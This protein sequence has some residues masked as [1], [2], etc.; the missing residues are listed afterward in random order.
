[1]TDYTAERLNKK[2]ASA[3]HY[4]LA[5]L[6]PYTEANVKLAFKPSAFF[7]DLEKLD[8][9]KASKRVLENAYYRAIKSGLIIFDDN[10]MPRLT[11]KAIRKIKPYKPKKLA[12]SNLMIVFDIPESDKYKRNHLR[13][14]LKEL[15][16]KQVQK[17]VWMSEYDTREYLY[18]EIKQYGLRQFV[19]IFEA[20]PIK[21]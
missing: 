3:T 15:S 1:M 14:L 21:Y 6:I 19:K 16:F 2:Y 7:N 18:M 9:I 11:P 10:G 20:R 17:S 13:T 8:R 5:G 12:N 4:I